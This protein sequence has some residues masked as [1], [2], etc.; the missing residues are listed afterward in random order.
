MLS[1]IDRPDISEEPN[2]QIMSDVESEGQKR[3]QSS[4][5][6]LIADDD[7]V[8]PATPQD[9]GPLPC[10]QETIPS[11]QDPASP[12]DPNASFKTELKDDGQVESGAIPSSLTP[13][14]SSQRTAGR[15]ARSVFEVSHQALDSLFPPPVTA[16]HG[17]TSRELPPAS[18]YIPPAPSM[19]LGASAD[20]LRSM[21]QACIN[22]HARLK[23]QVAHDRFQFR[24]LEM[25]A[26]EDA[27]RAAIEFEITRCEVEKLKQIELSRQ[28]RNELS[29]TQESRYHE[30][31]T[32]FQNVV[33]ENESLHMKL[34]SAK[35]VI[36]QKEGN[37]IALTEERDMLLT[38]IRENREHFNMLCSPGGIFHAFATPNSNHLST[39]R[40]G[41]RGNRRHTHASTRHDP[42]HGQERFAALLEVLHQ[43]NN[44]A[45]PTPLAATHTPRNQAKH[46]RAV[47]SMS[48]LPRTPRT[49]PRGEQSGLLP[50]VDLVPQ[51]EPP[52]RYSGGF[53]TVGSGNRGPS[54]ESTISAEDNEELAR[55]AVEA[56]AQ[57]AFLF[58]RR[59]RYDEREEVLESHASQAASELLRRD[60]RESFEVVSSTGSRDVTPAPAEKTAKL[61]AR[62]YGGVDKVLAGGAGK[63]RFSGSCDERDEISGPRTTAHG[64][65]KKSRVEMEGRRVGLGIQYGHD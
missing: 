31:K 47:Q 33:Q 1:A 40:Q 34:K 6:N 50:S 3:P 18:E 10:S 7:S 64:P 54:R 35:K 36:K 5:P 23:L 61:Q 25:Q 21:L 27:E 42:E 14:P 45:P 58:S 13:P 19:V 8:V 55:Q 9:I 15:N 22:E 4:D 62:L 57:S 41:T 29:A 59:S 2:L 16:S 53:S 44:S 32:C 11:T 46:T 26:M 52:P 38:R 17:A 30:L 56:A 20:K 24:L 63:R 28:A 49:R 43:E 60:P 48:S 39:P 37:I 65:N 12:A 51:S